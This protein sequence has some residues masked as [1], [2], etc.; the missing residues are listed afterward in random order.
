MAD[1]QSPFLEVAGVQKKY[2]RS[3]RSPTPAS[4][5]AAERYTPFSVTTVQANR[6]C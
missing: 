4:P 3:S 2:A 1:V 5:S 6:R